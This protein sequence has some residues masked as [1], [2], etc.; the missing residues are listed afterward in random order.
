M[1][2]WGGDYPDGKV[3]ILRPWMAALAHLREVLPGTHY[4]WVGW[5]NVREVFSANEAQLI[6]QSY[7]I[8]PNYTAQWRSYTRV[9]PGLSPGNSNL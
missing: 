8:F 7:L 3:L 4:S 6:V 2:V 1:G 9:N 5:S